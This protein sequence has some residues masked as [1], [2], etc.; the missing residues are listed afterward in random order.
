MQGPGIRTGP[1]LLA[2]DNGYSKVHSGSIA[3]P[4]E[5]IAADGLVPHLYDVF[6]FRSRRAHLI[7]DA[8]N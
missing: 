3:R 6:P 1:R 8:R 4:R 7:A 5:A 2:S